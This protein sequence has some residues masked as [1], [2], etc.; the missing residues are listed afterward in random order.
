MP[1]T[2]NVE[3]PQWRDFL[4]QMSTDWKPGEHWAFV[5]PTGGGKTNF[6]SGLLKT[7]KYVLALDVK[8]GDKTLKKLGW[9]RLTKWPP[10]HS[11]RQDMADGKPFRRIVGS[12]DKTPAGKLKRYALSKRILG[13]VL[14]EG[15]WTVLGT[16]AKILTHPK[17][18]G[19]WDDWEELL[20]LARDVEVSVLTD[21]QRV[22]GQPREAS[23]QA[24]W[25]AVGYTRDTDAVNRL[26]EMMGRSRAE[27]RGAVEAL[28]ELPFG[29]LVVSRDPYRPI[30]VTRA[31][32][33]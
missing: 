25:L 14:V 6:A 28:A 15:G 24:T 29:F 18:G 30:I 10:T 19:L 1:R 5:V 26:G 4:K 13:D 27:M 11:D 20:L 31:D 32:L 16:D 9:E 3:A 22:S 8:G 12:T 7:R 23:D 17:F 2:L 33:L 21:F